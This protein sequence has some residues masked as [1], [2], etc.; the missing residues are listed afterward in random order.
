MHSCVLFF[1][2]CLFVVYGYG[3]TTKELQASQK[4]SLP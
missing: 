2:I 4:S 1:V 3:Y